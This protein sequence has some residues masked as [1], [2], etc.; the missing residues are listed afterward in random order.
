MYRYLLLMLIL[1]P[2]TVLAEPA[3]EN[4]LATTVNGDQVILHPNGRWQYVDE[5][6]AEVA[7]KAFAQFPE[8]QVCPPGWQG[9][10]FGLGRCIPP[11]D[12][13]FNRTSRIGK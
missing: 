3:S 1:A 10:H 4:L 7:S 5:R 9:G 11:G 13:D 8:N 12:K 2:L 6:K